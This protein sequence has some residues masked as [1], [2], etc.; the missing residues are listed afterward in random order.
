M[1]LDLADQIFKNEIAINDFNQTLSKTV[2]ASNTHETL[3]LNLADPRVSNDVGAVNEI[4]RIN[5]DR[6]VYVTQSEFGSFADALALMA[7]QIEEL[8]RGQENV[9]SKITAVALNSSMFLPAE[10]F[11]QEKLEI[12]SAINSSNGLMEFLQNVIAS[13]SNSNVEIEQELRGLSRGVAAL[14][15]NDSRRVNSGLYG[16]EF[17]HLLDA[18]VRDL[19]MEVTEQRTWIGNQRR[20]IRQLEGELFENHELNFETLE[21]LGVRKTQRKIVNSQQL[22]HVIF[23]ASRFNLCSLIFQFFKKRDKENIVA[24]FKYLYNS[25]RPNVS[26]IDLITF[27]DKNICI[28]SIEND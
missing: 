6:N 5:N 10:T 1:L 4:N 16:D 18:S 26:E 13:V 15:S 14:Q 12:W 3:S 8:D 27:S 25:V 9:K 11:A 28:C 7:G 24:F 2:K 19:R 22:D 17:I 20:R 23:I 21:Y